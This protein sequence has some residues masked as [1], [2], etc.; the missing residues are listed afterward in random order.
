M[1]EI[2]LEN[3]SNLLN[4][5]GRIKKKYDDLA[6]YTGENYNVFNVLGIYHD[7]LSHSKVIGDLLNVKGCHGQKDTFLELF[8]NEIN[9]FNENTEQHKVLHNFKTEN[10]STHIEKYIGKVEFSNC[11][12]GRI[13]ILIND[14]SNNIIIE[15]KVWAGDQY[16]QLV[17]YNNQDKKAPIIYLTLE[18]KEPSIDSISDKNDENRLTLGKDFVCISYRTNIVNWLENCIKEME[19][20][21]IIRE[22][23]NQY[24]V[25]VKQL[26][27]QSTN[28]KM[29]EEI[30]N[31]LVKSP[32]NLKAAKA[33]SDNYQNALKKINLKLINRLFLF[34]NELGIETS[35]NLTEKSNRVDDVFIPLKEFELEDVELGI[36]IELANNHYFFCIVEKNK[37][38]DTN[39]N[40][41]NK[42]K[43]IKD[44]LHSRVENLNVFNGWTIGKSHEFIIGLDINDYTEENELNI[45]ALKEL[46]EKI[47][48]FKKLLNS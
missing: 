25:L 1:R 42:F 41:N 11:V 5:V 46:A 40:T 31:L 48:N 10:S 29:K 35:I 12:G 6:E 4:Q 44:F 23:L 27:H 20:K 30:I 39:F 28:N 17:R 21:P 33:I 37:K 32:E 16:L 8:L 43:N 26:T 19:N 15:N 38:R 36:N 9:V 22:S 7:E 3:I 24:L 47:N 18:G 34:L 2:K 13:D 14:G 45:E